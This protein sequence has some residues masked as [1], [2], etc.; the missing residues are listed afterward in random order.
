MLKQP[1]C[2]GD[3]FSFNSEPDG[4]PFGV[5]PSDIDDI[6]FERAIELDESPNR[7][8]VDVFLILFRPV[9]CALV[10]SSEPRFCR[11]DMVLVS[12]LGVVGTGGLLRLEGFEEML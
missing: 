4:A 3:P 10:I 5:R 2:S 6:V 12:L 11:P 1:S 7:A 8:F 9:E